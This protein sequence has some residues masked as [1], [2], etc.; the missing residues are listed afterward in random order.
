MNRLL[1]A[2]TSLAL[3]TFATFW[4]GWEWRDRSAD[5]KKLRADLEL[6]ELVNDTLVEAIDAERAKAAELAAIAATYEREKQDAQAV[7]D[8]VVA[9]LLADNL[10]LSKRWAGCAAVPQAGAAAGEPDAAFADRAESAARIIRAAAEC[11][12]QIRGL[13]AVI[14]ADRAEVKP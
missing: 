6:A 7:A 14:L 5:I 10:R 8:R 2:I 13:Q 12:A 11:D 4:I 9:D 3:W 1:I